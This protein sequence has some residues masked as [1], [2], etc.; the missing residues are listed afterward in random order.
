MTEFISSSFT[1]AGNGRK[2]LSEGL[3]VSNFRALYSFGSV[4]LSFT[5]SQ[6][7][8]DSHGSTD[9][10]LPNSSVDGSRYSCRTANQ[11]QDVT[12]RLRSMCCQVVV[13]ASDSYP[14]RSH[15]HILPIFYSIQWLCL[16]Y[17]WCEW[18]GLSDS[19]YW[20]KCKYIQSISATLCW[21]HFSWE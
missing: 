19:T 20:V 18:Q 14:F 6:N 17:N 5:N 15:W 1:S 9:L 7:I 10:I 13:V 16:Q 12:I 21:C 11:S 8:G 3:S 4:L 2:N